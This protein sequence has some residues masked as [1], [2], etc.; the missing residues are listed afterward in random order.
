MDTPSQSDIE[1]WIRPERGAQRQDAGYREWLAAEI[2]AGV[3][4]LDRGE[5]MTAAEAWK[6]LG[7]E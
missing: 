2:E 5:G 1:R 6:S 7:L 3:S 4:E